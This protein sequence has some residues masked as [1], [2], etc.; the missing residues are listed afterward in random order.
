MWVT[1]FLSIFCSL[2]YVPNNCTEK[3]KIVEHALFTTFQLIFYVSLVIV[4]FLQVAEY[5][6]KTSQNMDRL[7]HVA[8]LVN[9]CIDQSYHID[10][11]QK[12]ENQ[13]ELTHEYNQLYWTCLLSVVTAI[14]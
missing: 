3:M 1:A 6:Y 13:E 9:N 2:S 4:W 8:E 7:S 5:E 12:Y 14:L 11:Q 10:M